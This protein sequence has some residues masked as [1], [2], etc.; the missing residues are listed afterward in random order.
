MSLVQITV[1]QGRLLSLMAS[2]EGDEQVL[3]QAQEERLEPMVKLM[4][5]GSL[6]ALDKGDYKP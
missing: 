1:K 3:S 5:I 6:R 4:Q 2:Q